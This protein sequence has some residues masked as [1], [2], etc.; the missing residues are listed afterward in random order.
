MLEWELTSTILILVVLLL[1][2][3]A[4]GKITLRMQYALWLVVAIRLLIPITFFDSNVSAMGMVNQLLWQR[5][6][7]IREQAAIL[8]PDEDAVL[9]GEKA[10][11]G[12]LYKGEETGAEKN[13]TT[14]TIWKMVWLAGVLTG[15][16]VC[17]AVN[18]HFSLRLRTTRR[19]KEAVEGSMLPVYET[20]V[21]S[22]PCLYGLFHPAVYLNPENVEEGNLRY[23]LAHENMHY[24]H[25]DH[26]WAL[27]RLFCVCLHWYNPMVWLAASI[28]R[29]D[30][31]LA[32]DEG[33]IAILGEQERKHYGEALLS[34]IA[35]G[36]GWTGGFCTATTMMGNKKSIKERIMRIM[37]QI[38]PSRGIATFVIAM[39]LLVV[40]FVF[41]G[42]K[43]AISE[44][45]LISQVKNTGGYSKERV[46]EV[47]WADYD[48]DGREDAFVAVFDLNGDVEISDFEG[49][50]ADIWYYDGKN[51]KSQLVSEMPWLMH[52][53]QYIRTV[54]LQDKTF[55]ICT[56]G[57][58]TGYSSVVYGIRDG[59]VWDYFE[60]YPDGYIYETDGNELRAR[61]Y[62]LQHD[63]EEDMSM[64]RISLEKSLYYDAQTDAL[65]AYEG[66]G[67]GENEIRMMRKY[68]EVLEDI[69]IRHIWPDGSD[70]RYLEEYGDI[71]DNHF[72]IYDIDR[73]GGEELIVQFSTSNMAELRNGI[74]DSGYEHPFWCI[75]FL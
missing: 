47:Y 23:I 19:R 53:P 10:V 33:A 12:D 49:Y 38:A 60:E 30:C 72:A 6:V 62:I 68:M 9:E 21:V 11:A 57:Y 22:S 58:T 65:V 31:E 45:E 73:D 2:R 66:D 41:T 56:S 27:L 67:L 29:Q 24:R 71:S 8:N 70:L 42:G 40:V 48:R 59:Q 46:F 3:V 52:A 32:C 7:Q 55:F 13:I 44:Q 18:L 36:S 16:V 28:C 15:L 37:A 34:V 43:Q 75:Y 69:R 39:M 5:T 17:L 4:R 35:V 61:V 1:R 25:K 64:G 74:N 26:I 50:N 63:Y 14:V 54:T 20:R 51:A